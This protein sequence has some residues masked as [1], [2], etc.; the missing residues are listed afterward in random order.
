MTDIILKDQCIEVN[1]NLTTPTRPTTVEKET[2][3]HKVTKLTIDTIKG[4]RETATHKVTTLTNN[5]TKWSTDTA[6]RR[7]GDSNSYV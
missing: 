7:I 4:S 6:N 3:T 2:A 5:T 1:H